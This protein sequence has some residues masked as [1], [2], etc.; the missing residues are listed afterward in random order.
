MVT[1]GYANTALGKRA[2]SNLISGSN[3]ISIGAETG[4]YP[5]FSLS[6]TIS[7]G[8]DGILNA[9]SNKAFMGNLSTGWTQ[10]THYLVYVF[11]WKSEK[12]GYR[13]CERA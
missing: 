3:N 2:L 9:A 4:T 13:R 1:L 10:G 7:I 11:G 5:N 6:N 8:N 12:Y